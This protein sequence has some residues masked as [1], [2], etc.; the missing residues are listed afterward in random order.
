MSA[1]MTRDSGSSTSD[2]PLLWAE[3]CTACG[4]TPDGLWPTQGG[5]ACR[6]IEDN[7]IFAEGDGYGRPFR[8]RQD[9]RE[10]V[11]DWCE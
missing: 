2:Q 5:I 10:F 8:L 1:T 11:W 6:W 9:Q 3:G 4:W 7:L